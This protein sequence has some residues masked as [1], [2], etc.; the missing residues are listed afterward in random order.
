MVDGV[1]MKPSVRPAGHPSLAHVTLLS[2]LL[3]LFMCIIVETH[4]NTSSNEEEC[5]LSCPCEKCAI[6]FALIKISN[7]A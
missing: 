6:L 5:R 3:L 1:S 7:F 4:I 2:Y